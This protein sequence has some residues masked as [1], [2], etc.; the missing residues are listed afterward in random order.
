MFVCRLSNRLRAFRQVG[1]GASRGRGRRLWARSSRTISSYSLRHRDWRTLHVVASATS[2]RVV[3]WLDNGMRAKIGQ[4][5]SHS[6][7]TQEEQLAIAIVLIGDKELVKQWLESKFF[8]VRRVG[9][10]IV[11]LFIVAYI[12]LRRVGRLIVYL[13][14]HTPFCTDD[15]QHHKIIPCNC[16][17]GPTNTNLYQWRGQSPFPQTVDIID[18]NATSGNILVVIIILVRV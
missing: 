7:C 15:E 4:E 10:L 16:Q 9:R 11:Y 6:G 1:L 5:S 18:M 17:S 13:F 2:S 8:V 3:R 12:G 14:Q